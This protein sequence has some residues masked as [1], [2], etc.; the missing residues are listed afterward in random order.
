MFHD[1]APRPPCRR[2][3]WRFLPS[4]FGLARPWPWWTSG[5]Q[6][7]EQTISWN[8]PLL[9]SLSNKLKKL[10]SFFLLGQKKN[11]LDPLITRHSGQGT[12][13][14]LSEKLAVD[15]QEPGT[16]VRGLQ[17][18]DDSATVNENLKREN[19]VKVTNHNEILQSHVPNSSLQTPMA[20]NSLKVS[21]FC[22]N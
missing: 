17:G 18:V 16:Q 1:Q 13:I 10:L 22:R 2:H 15:P 21:L 8:I 3:R 11:T 20:A 9:P 5:E 7:R 12:R 14:F 4:G 6:R 19:R